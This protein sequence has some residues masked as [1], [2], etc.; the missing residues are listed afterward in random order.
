V[1][2]AIKGFGCDAVVGCWLLRLDEINYL[3]CWHM[4]KLNLLQLVHY[5]QTGRHVNMMKRDNA[6]KKRN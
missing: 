4:G 1:V 3:W 2:V 6:S 5:D